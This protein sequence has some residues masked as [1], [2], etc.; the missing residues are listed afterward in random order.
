[1]RA[2]PRL[3]DTRIVC[4][5]GF[6][7]GS[8]AEALRSAGIDDFVKKPL[9]LLDLKRRIERLLPRRTAGG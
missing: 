2:D 8:D 1:V 3:A 9:D 6:L 5:S 7:D 4:M